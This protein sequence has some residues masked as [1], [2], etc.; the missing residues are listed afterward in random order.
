MSIHICKQY[1]A[2]STVE[3]DDPEEIELVYDLYINYLTVNIAVD[4][5]VAEKA[6]SLERIRRGASAPCQ[7]LHY[8][9]I[10]FP[11]F[12]ALQAYGD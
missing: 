6:I 10:C 7:C 1:I 4:R 3:L 5:S 12:P 11:A 8:I 2:N 9:S